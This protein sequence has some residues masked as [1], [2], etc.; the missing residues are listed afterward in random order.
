MVRW[1]GVGWGCLG[2]QNVSQDF[3]AVGWGRVGSQE[4]RLPESA[5]DCLEPSGKGEVQRGERPWGGK[6]KSLFPGL[7]RRVET[8]CP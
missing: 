1:F 5:M 6:T 3:T 2:G 4:G 7:S 8:F